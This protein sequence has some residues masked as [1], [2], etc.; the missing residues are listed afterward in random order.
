VTNSPLINSL[1]A[2]VAAAPD[3]LPLRLHLAELLLDAGD[4]A[5]AVT[6]L[7]QA[8]VRDPASE[9][10]RNLMARAVGAPANVPNT[11]PAAAETPAEPAAPTPAPA[12]V[13][14]SAFEAELA[15]AVPPRFVDGSG[16]G[17]QA[18]PVAGD[19][20]GIVEVE[21]TS[22]MLADVGGMQD[23]K[24]RLEVSFFGPLKNPQMRKLYG[25]SLRGGLLLYGPPGCGKTFLARAVAGEM[26]AKF[27]SVPI[28][29]VL[30]MY[31]G[32]SEQ[33]LHEVFEAARRNAPCVLFLDEIDALGYKRSQMTSSLTRTLGNQLLTELD[34]VDGGNE[35]V[36]V[37]A[38]TNAPWDVDAA[39]RRPGRFDRMVLV[40]PPD[41]PAR[42]AI[43]EYH[44]RE[45]P[46]A[47][48]DVRKLAAATEGYSGA[49]LAHVCDTAAEGALYDSMK[50]GEIRMIEQRDMEAALREVRPSTGPW[51]AT[52]RNVA[53]FANE[54][55]AYDELAAYLKRHK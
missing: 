49:D 2:A 36:Y 46:V 1:V 16:E 45:R 6:Q 18:E 41:A 19:A 47:G 5:G 4:T 26:G 44:L 48:I 15:D 31:I 38:A 25:K 42:A 51:I 40:A 34:G 24:R 8:L 50:S 9:A 7:A 33:N 21:S 17:G 13:D 35:G 43:L 52:A 29:E 20:D 30:N 39:L 10:A 32:R 3:D 53:M 12:P 37:L 54:G 23:V 28:V 55:G 27:I 14:W 22:L 11:P